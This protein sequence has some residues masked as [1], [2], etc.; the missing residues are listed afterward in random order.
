M[1]KQNKL[2]LTKKL[3]GGYLHV[4]K[5]PNK[6]DTNRG[7]YSSYLER[8]KGGAT[9][10]KKDSSKQSGDKVVAIKLRPSPKKNPSSKKRG[11]K[12]VKAI[13]NIIP[14]KKSLPSSEKPQVAKPQVAKHKGV[15]IQN[16]MVKGS[17]KKQRVLKNVTGKSKGRRINKSLTKRRNNSLKKG[18]R[19][20]VTKIRKYS[21]K[22]ISKIQSRLKDIN[23]KSNEQ[24]KQE[25]DK[26]G[27]KL[28]GKS[29]EILKDIYMYSQLCGINIK[30]E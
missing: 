1:I 19:I 9:Q 20:S 4:R 25:L 8:N 7:G 14:R 28:S 16:P 27:V 5:S 3:D 18:K 2:S 10:V 15:L 22:D 6:S 13:P 17:L 23:K 12:G 30:R 11:K 24:I 21:N 29:P 26:Q